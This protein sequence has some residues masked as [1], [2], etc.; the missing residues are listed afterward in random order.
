MQGIRIIRLYTMFI[1]V[2]FAS[3]TYQDLCEI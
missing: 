1:G 3:I 2:Y